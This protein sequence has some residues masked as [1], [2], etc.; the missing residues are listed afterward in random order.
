MATGSTRAGS[1]SHRAARAVFTAQRL[2]SGARAYRTLSGGGCGAVRLGSPSSLHRDSGCVEDGCSRTGNWTSWAARST[3]WASWAE[4]PGMRGAL[5]KDL[6]M[7]EEREA[8]AKLWTPGW[9]VT[10]QAKHMVGSG[11]PMLLGV[12]L[13]HALTWHVSMPPCGYP[14]HKLW[15]KMSPGYHRLLLQMLISMR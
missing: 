7:G 10:C 1:F 6:Q 11:L 14:A 2:C 9:E 3:G 15:L 8:P 12:D 5:G 4:C 13:S